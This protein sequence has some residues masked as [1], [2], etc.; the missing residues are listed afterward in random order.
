MFVYKSTYEALEQRLKNAQNH[1][2]AKNVELRKLTSEMKVLK[3]T[4]NRN[5]LRVEQ[6]NGD[7][8]KLTDSLAGYKRIV[9]DDFKTMKTFVQD[10]SGQDAKFVYYA[11]DGRPKPLAS[12]SKMSVMIG[13]VADTL[14]QR[15][16]E[17][18]K[19]EQHVED[20]KRKLQEFKKY[21]AVVDKT[22][23][24]RENQTRALNLRI[25]DVQ[26]KLHTVTESRIKKHNMLLQTQEKLLK[27]Q[28]DYMDSQRQ[29]QEL[30]SKL[31]QRE[32]ENKKL[33]EE[34]NSR[35]SKFVDHLTDGSNRKKR[36]MTNLNPE[37][38]QY[39]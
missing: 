13:Y 39:D 7:I 5:K 10:V 33:E 32:Q 14:S 18:Q 19:L 31:L 3:D 35:F 8:K 23:G 4:A 27:S 34:L 38:S 37:A 11:P 21:K 12:G 26:K 24:E 17:M 22:M 1:A 15:E 25:E 2:N 30:Q 29:I 9:E 28:N 6:A 16:E 36:K 20:L